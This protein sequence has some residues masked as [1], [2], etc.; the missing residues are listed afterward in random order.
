MLYPTFSKSLIYIASLSCVSVLTMTEAKSANLNFLTDSGFENGYAE[1]GESYTDV[2]NSPLSSGSVWLR[3]T[4]TCD[5]WAGGPRNRVGYGAM[6]GNWGGLANGLP[7]VP[8]GGGNFAACGGWYP[9]GERITQKVTGAVPGQKYELSFWYAHAGVEGATPKNFMARAGLWVDGNLIGS[10]NKRPYLGAGKQKWHK[11]K[12]TYTAT[13]SSFNFT[14]GYKGGNRADY[15]YIAF[16]GASV[17]VSSPAASVVVIAKI[18]NDDLGTKIVSDLGIVAEAGALTFDAGLFSGATSTT[19]YTS[20]PISITPG[21]TKLTAPDVTDYTRVDDLWSC[22]DKTNQPITVQ[23]TIAN[24]ALSASFTTADK[25]TITCTISYNDD[26]ACQAMPGEVNV[27]MSPISMFKHETDSNNNDI[28]KLF[29]AITNNTDHT[30][31][32]K[33]FPIGANENPASTASWNATA[34][35]QRATRLF[36]TVGTTPTLFSALPDSL[37]L[38]H[39][40]PGA[41]TVKTNVAAASMGEISPES[42]IT[43]LQSD[44]NSLMY[45]AEADYQSF[46]RSTIKSRSA[47]NGATVLS[48]VLV[49]SDDGFLYSFNQSNGALNWGWMPSSLVKQKHTSSFTSQHYMN[50]VIDQLDL[51]SGT[52]GSY[53]FDSYV[54]GSYKGGL[55]QYVLKVASNSGLS[56]VVWDTDHAVSNSL[57]DSAP[58]QGQRAYFNDANGIQYMAY[59]ITASG[60]NSVLHIRSMATNLV[61]EQI[62]LG[63]TATSTPFVMPD[64]KKSLAPTVNKIYLGDANGKVYSADLFQADNTTLNANFNTAFSATATPVATIHPNGHSA[65]AVLQVGASLAVGGRYY[66]QVQAEDRL[67]LLQYQSANWQPSWTTSTDASKTGKWVTTNG[68]RAF[69]TDS[70]I[71]SLPADARITGEA[72]VIANSLVLPV[73]LPPVGDACDNRAYYYF[74]KLSNGHIPTKT[75]YSSGNNSTAITSGSITLGKGDAKRMNLTVGAKSQKLIALGLSGQDINGASGLK[76]TFYVNDPVTS[77][78]RSWKE[79]H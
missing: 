22:T 12:F 35:A 79:L 28:N 71:P 13:S 56:S 78:L 58:N 52:T 10:T 19:T 14:M 62:S 76:T 3:T 67:T 7:A 9:P 16:D 45:L 33:A 46:Y 25:N 61:H 73:T 74:Y 6:N 34:S 75:F 30:G 26:S 68:V 65:S 5:A 21:T 39:S 40:V 4:G 59:I 32:L 1:S 38:S 70:N 15:G 31:H 41:D 44:I 42:T 51:K 29:I 66:L 55:G 2:V 43:L 64:F 77:G 49:T 11:A 50:G 57:T 27:A 54:V 48:Q 36:S 23:N 18:I 69:A 17:T 8:N 53:Q 20:D 72:Y 47:V 37:F 24:A 63:F 60:T